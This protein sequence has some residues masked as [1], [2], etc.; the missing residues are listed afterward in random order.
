MTDRGTCVPA[1]P[2]SQAKPSARAGYKA[3]TRA[4]SNVTRRWYRPAAARQVLGS[5]GPYGERVS[6]PTTG[7]APAPSRAVHAA[8]GAVTT[9]VVS[10]MPVFLVGGLAVQISHDLRLT[11]T[12]L[13]LLVSVYF[14]VSALG[15][16]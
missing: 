10:V 5:A 9:T 8:V 11:P 15:S 16:L 14:G 7:R 4:T 3:R 12:S 2:S 13:G 1:A 6:P